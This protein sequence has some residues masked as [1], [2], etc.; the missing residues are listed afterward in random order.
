MK[1]VRAANDPIHANSAVV[2]MA[3]SG[4][5]VRSLSF[6]STGEVHPRHVPTAQ[7]EILAV[8]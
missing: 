6:D 4:D 7:F 2:G 5:W 8:N 1:A 3:D